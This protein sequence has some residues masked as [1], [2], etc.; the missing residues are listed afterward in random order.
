MEKI[1]TIPEGVNFVVD[2]MRVTAKGDGKEL[3]KTFNAKN[4]NISLEGDK[5]TIKTQKENKRELKMLGTIVAHMNNMI[6]GLTEGF[7]YKM[8]IATVHFPM[9]VK[10][11][12]GILLIKSLLGEK[13][14]RQA[15]ILPDVKLEI[16]GSAI[17]IS[18]HDIE[19]AGQT[20]ANIEKATKVKGRDRRIFQDGIFLTEKPNK[21][22]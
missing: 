1:I 16:K 8:E 10:E 6:K 5:I 14:D 21:I 7:N 19:A 2:G 11:E 9:T 22:I 13:V 20:A 17:E 15:K 12:N 3:S 4:V 18:S